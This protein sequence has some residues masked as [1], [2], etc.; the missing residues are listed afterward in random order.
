MEVNKRIMLRFKLKHQEETK[1]LFHLEMDITI[2]RIKKIAN[3]KLS[4]EI[5][6]FYFDFF[7]SLQF[8]YVEVMKFVKKII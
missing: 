6:N 7:L 5:E 1:E 2:L 4:L 8:P 3:D